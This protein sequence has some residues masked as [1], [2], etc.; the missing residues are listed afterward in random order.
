MFKGLFQRIELY[1]RELFIYT[2]VF[3]QISFY[4]SIFKI[5]FIVINSVI[6]MTFYRN[7]I[8]Y[9]DIFVMFNV[10]VFFLV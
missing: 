3:C 4:Q 9:F 2:R 10:E 5:I 6:F 8:I 7:L 1:E